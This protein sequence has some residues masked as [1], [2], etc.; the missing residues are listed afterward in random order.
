MNRK[1]LA[2]GLPDARPVS[3]PR[4][5][6]SGAVGLLR[7]ADAVCEGEH[8]EQTLF[9]SDQ[10]LRQ[11]D[12]VL[13]NPASGAGSQEAMSEVQAALMQALRTRL[14]PELAVFGAVPGAIAQTASWVSGG[15]D[16]VLFRSSRPDQPTLRMVIRQ[17]QL[18]DTSA[19]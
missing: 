8:F 17:R 19:L 10:T 9:S 11:M 6:S 2:P 3:S 14:G 18:V 1:A 7:I 13:R 15:A 12:L 16:V 5:L 4:R